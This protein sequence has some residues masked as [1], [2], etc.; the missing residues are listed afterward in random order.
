MALCM[1]CD[2][3]GSFKLFKLVLGTRLY[4]NMLAVQ[5]HSPGLTMYTAAVNFYIASTPTPSLCCRLYLH[6][7]KRQPD[8]QAC[9]LA[10]G[11]FHQLN[12]V[13]RSHAPLQASWPPRLLHRDHPVL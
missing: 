1:M 8:G 6:F 3:E 2:G 11:Q 4:Q 9:F 13:T 5:S 7:A 12:P 10:I